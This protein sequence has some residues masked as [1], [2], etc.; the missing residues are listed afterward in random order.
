MRYENN[1]R[2]GKTYECKI[3]AIDLQQTCQLALPIRNKCLQ[4]KHTI[5][6]L[7]II[8]IISKYVLISDASR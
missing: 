4:A 5:I 1:L 7:L 6:F 8:I 3:K 2:E